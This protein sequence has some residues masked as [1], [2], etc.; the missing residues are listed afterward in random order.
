MNP[1]K[2]ILPLLFL[3]QL[4]LAQGTE[5]MYAIRKDKNW[6]FYNNNNELLFPNKSDIGPMMVYPYYHG[7]A[8]VQRLK[9]DG[10]EI[11]FQDAVLDE[12]GNFQDLGMIPEGFLITGIDLIEGQKVLFWSNWNERFFMSPDGKKV[13]E[14][15]SEETQWLGGRL[16]S[17]TEGNGTYKVW[18]ILDAKLLFEVEADALGRY[19]NGL[20][21]AKKEGLWGAVNLKGEWVIAP[22]FKAAGASNLEEEYAFEPEVSFRNG[23]LPASKDS[24][25]WGLINAKGKWGIPPQ[26]A[27]ILYVGQ[28][29]WMG[30]TEKGWQLI[31]PKGRIIKK[32]LLEDTPEFAL[33]D[34]YVI[35]A[36]AIFNLKGKQIHQGADA[37]QILGDGFFVASMEG[38]LTLYKGRKR[39]KKLPKEIKLMKIHPFSNGLATV[40]VFKEGGKGY[41]GFMNQQGEWAI[42]PNLD[43]SYGGSGVPVARK[44]FIYLRIKGKHVFYGHDGNLITEI[45]SDGSW[46]MF[47]ILED[48]NSGF[49]APM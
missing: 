32:L 1:F 2:L 16:L 41:I 11:Y 9:R 35:G 17:D 8:K 38:Q 4:L 7:W 19:T 30:K 26:Y 14:D 25:N 33:F 40:E 44:N 49:W 48:G 13:P 21:A 43:V 31:N 18:D 6:E 27:E 3:S 34:Q 12:K 29:H 22:Q 10:T 28:D 39:I 37:Y 23:L 24:T 15:P 36:D 5:P 45:A 20:L 47:S 46:D 42:E